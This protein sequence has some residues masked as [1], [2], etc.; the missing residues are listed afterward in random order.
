MKEDTGM[1]GVREDSGGSFNKLS[2][3]DDVDEEPDSCGIMLGKAFINIFRILD[4]KAR[5]LDKSLV[6]YFF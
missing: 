1:V 4:V 2:G 3:S 5:C 6:L